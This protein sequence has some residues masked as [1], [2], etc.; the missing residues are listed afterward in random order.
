M[1]YR[2]RAPAWRR[3]CAQLAIALLGLGA[4]A[5]LAAQSALLASRDSLRLKSE[6]SGVLGRHIRVHLS[7]VSIAAALAEVADAAYARISFSSDI[8][9]REPRVSLTSD[10]IALGDAFDHILQGTDLDVVVTTS[11]YVVLVRGHGRVSN[12]V[13][14]APLVG[15]PALAL[16]E[17]AAAMRPQLIDRVL[18]MGSPVG[19]AAER[20]LSSA[21]TVYTAAQISQMQVRSMSELLRTQIPGMVA[22]DLGA[23]GP[24]SQIGSVRGSSSFAANYLKTYVDG[25]ELASPYLLFAI[26]PSS[27][28]RIEII[29]GPQGS[30][31][32]GSDAI[33]GVVQVVTR[34]G[35]PSAR[36]KLHGD[37]SSSVG[38]QET[39]FAASNPATQRHSAMAWTG[40]GATSLGVGGT[41]E[42]TGAIVEGGSSGYRGIYGGGRSALGALKLDATAR[43]ADI[44]FVAPNN[45]LLRGLPAVASLRTPSPSDEQRVETETYGVTLDF[46]PSY[47]WR[48]TLVVGIDRHDGA[49]APQ[50]EP[51]TVADALLG[52][53]R[54]SVSKQSL[55]YSM[56]ARA[57]LGADAALSATAGAERSLLNRQRLGIREDLGLSGSGLAALYRDNVTNSGVFGQVKLDLFN[58]LFLSAGLRGENSTS[59]GEEFGTALSPMLGAAFTRDV[60]E[61]TIKLRMA[62]GKGIRP[63][64]PSM[65]L[66]IQTLGF[67][68]VA[69]PGLEPEEQS[70]IEG[71]IEVYSSDRLNLSVT[72]YSQIADGLIQQVVASPRTN[73]RF[74]QY[75]NAGRIGNTGIEI[76]GSSRV[77]NLRGDVSWSLTRSVVQALAPRYTGELRVGDRVPE[78]PS[79]SGLVSFTW[80]R[81]RWRATAGASYVGNWVG[82]DWISYYDAQQAGDV[83]RPEL[84]DFWVRYPALVKPFVGATYTMRR[85]AEW[86]VRVDN[87]TNLQRNERDD[88]Q[89]SGGRTATLGLKLTR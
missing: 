13:S 71:G 78:V 85:A 28:E 34:K 26:D 79:S 49:V 52:I 20:S 87:L 72:G 77:G 54:E 10:R 68:Q 61:S 5:P 1:N 64:H 31:L 22:W 81:P 80:E 3:A 14:T 55:R 66:S 7:E 8:I 63:P 69:N 44:R 53:S 29:R 6:R 46:N 35:S 16:T 11:G 33:S 41:Y 84:R 4:S 39:R 86:F 73:S 70:G 21:I 40:G 57:A 24:F 76:E 36:W 27:I 59:F 43:Y 74:V 51:A 83:S 89:I 42:S 12:D 88:L 65:R 17:G 19:G 2:C 67:R 30:A 62:Y 38:M 58:S 18:V 60:G 45:P 32:Y 56:T 48:Q 25:V 37:L 15:N 9:P 23:S 50:R 75:Q 47:W 82:Y